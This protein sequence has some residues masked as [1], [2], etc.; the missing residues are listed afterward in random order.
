MV[1][2]GHPFEGY[3][4]WH[5]P[6]TFLPVAALLA[7]M[8]YVPAQII[9]LV[10]TFCAYLFCLRGI[11]GER[12]GFFIAAAFPAVLANFIAGQVGF[13]SSAADRVRSCAHARRIGAI[14]LE[15]AGLGRA[16]RRGRHHGAVAQPRRR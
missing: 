14:G 15:R 3:F 5:Y 11:L 7:K 16:D 13:L 6:P 9:F 8:S 10:S 1:A 2:L 12:T 4:G